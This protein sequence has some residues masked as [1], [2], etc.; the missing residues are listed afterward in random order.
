MRVANPRCLVLFVAVTLGVTATPAIGQGLWSNGDTN[1]A[2]A[3]IGWVNVRQFTSAQ[4][5]PALAVSTRVHT[6]PMIMASP[7]SFPSLKR[8]RFQRSKRGSSV[9]SEMYWASSFP[10]TGAIMKP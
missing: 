3:S 10:I 2:N 1:G 9:F 8:R 6:Q 4:V 5:T 7:S